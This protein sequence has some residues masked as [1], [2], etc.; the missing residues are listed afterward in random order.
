MTDEVWPEFGPMARCFIATLPR[1]LPRAMGRLEP[2]ATV[3]L[4]LQP[5][6]RDIWHDHVLF[7]GDKVTGMIDF[8]AVDIDTPATDIARLVGSLVGD[9]A[10]GWQSGIAAYS[11]V[12]PLTERR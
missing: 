10:A 5:C 4:N 9:D 12:R 6:L 7:T 1:I 3:S 2:L 8:G 11:D